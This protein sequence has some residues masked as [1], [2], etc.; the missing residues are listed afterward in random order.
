MPRPFPLQDLDSL[1]TLPRLRYLSLLDNPV[2]KQPNYRLYVVARCKALKS[3]DFRKVKQKVRHRTVWLGWCAAQD[4][5]AHVVSGTAASA[6][7]TC[8]PTRPLL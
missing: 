2:T 3:L 1:S 8:P 4:C 5:V 6:A 7:G